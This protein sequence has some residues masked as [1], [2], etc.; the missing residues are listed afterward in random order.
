MTWNEMQAL[1]PDLG[2]LEE[3]AQFAGERGADWWATLQAIHETLSKCCGSD[4]SHER[5]RTPAAYECAR[6]AIFAAWSRGAKAGSPA[7]A[8]DASEAC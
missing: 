4:A 8:V 2:R 1:E 5:L 6:A 3:S 7:V